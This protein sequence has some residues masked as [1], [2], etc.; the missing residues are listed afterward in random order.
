MQVS[1]IN[2]V[3]QLA[4]LRPAWQRL[5]KT[6]PS[7]SF[8]HSCQWLEATWDHAQV[9]QSLRVLVVG[10]PDQPIGILP[11][12][13]RQ[14]PRRFH[15]A[16]VLS[17][18]LDDWGPYYGPISDQ[19][20]STLRAGLEHILN[21]KRDW[22]IVDLRWTPPAAQ[23]HAQTLSTLSEFGLTVDS[24]V[25]HRTSII[26]LEGTWDEFVKSRSKNWRSHFRRRH[27][28]FLQ[29]GEVRHE[30]YR[31]RG[32]QQGESDPR[33]DLY[34]ACVELAAK[35]W[36]GS[37]ITGN[38]LN[39]AAVRDSL[40]AVHQQAAHLGC[41]DL[42]LVYL[43]DRPVSFAYNYCFQGH[44]FALRLG[45]DPEMA[46][47][48]P[49]NFVEELAIQDSFA[50][51][52]HIYELGPDA[53]ETKRQLRTRLEP[54]WQY[55]HYPRTVRSQLLRWKAVASSWTKGQPQLKGKR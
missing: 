5:W 46:K 25:R 50:R 20:E 40:R 33:W 26:D 12:V 34:D 36:Q 3:Q 8:F 22:D 19:P 43:D 16:R 27:K 9:E 39:H 13:V 30:R 32:H 17:Y 49:G 18:P 47:L 4:E 41:L 38:T 44:V 1:E 11:L 6:M 37:S 29:A 55:T 31:P 14:E 48:G 10:S 21:T 28:R 7:G 24:R 52:D 45:Y 53:E 2:D 15:A 51:G 54:I 42:N 23:D 35:S